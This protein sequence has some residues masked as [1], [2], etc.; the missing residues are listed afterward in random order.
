LVIIAVLQNVQG[1]PNG[2]VADP[3]EE[4][5]ENDPTLFPPPEDL[6]RYEL[7]SGDEAS[8]IGNFSAVPLVEDGEEV[9]GPVSK[10]A[11][12]ET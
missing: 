1:D 11:K 7:S 4:F 9:D 10:R 12:T 8:G 5:D 2:D 3:V 6:V